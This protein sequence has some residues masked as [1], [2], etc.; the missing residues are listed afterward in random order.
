MLLE[1]LAEI[2]YSIK[3][4]YILKEKYKTKKKLCVHL[5]KSKEVLVLPVFSSIL[6]Y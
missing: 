2:F 1:C 5:F 3:F 6:T 4:K